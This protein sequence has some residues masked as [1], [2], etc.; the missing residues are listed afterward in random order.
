MT[1]IIIKNSKL[2]LADRIIEAGIAIDDGKIVDIAKD[3]NLPTADKII[4][5]RGNFVLP[6]LI[7]SHVHLREPGLVYKEDFLTGTMAA[8]AGG[9]TTVLDMP[10]NKPP[11]LTL[12][13]LENKRKLAEKCIV[14]YGFHF[15][16]SKDNL[17]EIKKVKNIASVKVFMNISTGKL[18]IDDDS[19]LEEIFR[20]SR[21]IT[22]HAEEE[23]IEKA[24][25]VSKKYGNRLYLCHIT[26][27][28]WLG[29]LEKN[30]TSDIFIEVT[31][32]HLFL[33]KKDDTSGLTKVYPQLESE[34]DQKA[35]WRGIEKGIVDT[36]GSDHAPHLL[37]EKK[38]DNPPGGVPGLETMLPLLL[39]AV[40]E[41]R[42]TLRRILE[43]T[44]QNPTKIFMIKNKG[45]IEVGYDADLTI[46]D[47]NLEK[48]VDN[49]KLFT[50][51]KWS[52]FNGWKLKGWPVQ[53]FVR[54]Q[55]VFDNGNINKIKG[56]EIDYW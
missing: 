48:K 12:E 38:S 35:L 43:L 7:D 16:S 18:L 31:P 2:V 42:I 49:D 54:G 1:D 3:T 21:V 29:Y 51:C 9:V 23:K 25:N 28:E 24:I 39:N 8:A 17:E 36:I 50:K 41:K 13:D 53:T 45:K 19:I 6:G 56:K 32:H 44:S 14:D 26:K 27:K 34:D 55:L 11:I 4:D 52:P 22:V 5:A 37:E 33:S 47:M 30:K 15:G 40:N 10:N 46:V 20:S